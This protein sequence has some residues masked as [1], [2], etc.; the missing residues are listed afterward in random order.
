MIVGWA[1]PEKIVKAIKKTR[2]SAIICSHMEP[3]DSPLQ[4]AEQVPDEGGTT[5]NKAS[6]AERA[7]PLEPPNNLAQP[8]QSPAEDSPLDT[9]PSAEERI[10]PEADAAASPPAEFPRP[11]DVEEVHVIYHYPPDHRYRHN[12]SQSRSYDHGFAGSTST[13]L[14]GPVSRPEII[15]TQYATHNY[16]TYRAAP[17]LPEYASINYN[18][19]RPEPSSKQYATYNYNAYRQEPPPPQNATQNY[20]AYRAKPPLPQYVTNYNNYRPETSLPQYAS[21]NDNTIRPGPP[22]QQYVTRNTN[23]NEPP[24]V[25]SDT[26]NDNANHNYNAYR[27]EPTLPPQYTA[28]YYNYRPESSLPQYVSSNENTSTSPQQY[29]SRNT[30]RNEPPAVQGTSRNGNAN[31]NYN[32]YRT[33]P[34][35]PPQYAANYNNDRPESSLPRYVSN[36]DN[37]SRPEPPP[38]QYATS[39]GNTNRNNPP[40]MQSETLNVD[41]YRPEAPPVMYTSVNY[42]TYRPSPYVSQSE[43]VRPSALYYPYGRAVPHSEDTNYYHPNNGTDG[44]IASVFSDENPNSCTI[45]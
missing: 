29:V 26:Q 34:T 15:S 36:H 39:S 8:L 44:N 20:N 18:T 10:S 25:Q 19:Y 16:N 24:T 1:E 40:S 28:N 32:A 9:D 6:A 2:K 31:H 45:V 27:T 12:Y 43:Y 38:Q 17:L 11:R 37:N 5:A 7:S 13:N 30:N 35:L 41:T 42:N 33:K 22:P 4:P 14:T 3:E 21:S 23:M